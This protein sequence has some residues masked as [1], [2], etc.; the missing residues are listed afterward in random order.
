MSVELG[1]VEKGTQTNASYLAAISDDESESDE[2]HS[3]SDYSPNDSQNAGDAD[4]G[5]DGRTCGGDNPRP[6]DTARTEMSRSRFCNGTRRRWLFNSAGQR[7]EYVV[8]IV[9]LRI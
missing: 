4:Q 1:R 5:S 6:M 9:E 2:N 8:R 3:Q 7:I